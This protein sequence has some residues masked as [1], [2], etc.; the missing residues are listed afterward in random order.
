MQYQEKFHLQKKSVSDEIKQL[1]NLLLVKTNKKASLTLRKKLME[2]SK[3]VPSSRKTL[4]E[5][6]KSIPKRKPPKGGWK[7]NFK[8]K[9]T[10]QK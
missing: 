3:M 8:K 10:T 6:K 5:Y 4:M 7:S 9:P 1:Y 2:I